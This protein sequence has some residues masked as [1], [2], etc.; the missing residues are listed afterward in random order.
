MSNLLKSQIYKIFF[1][2]QGPFTKYVSNQKCWQSL[3]KGGSGVKQML[4]IADKGG[5]GGA[6]PCGELRSWAALL[7]S[8]T[9]PLLFIQNWAHTKR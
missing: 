7:G 1:L 2:H 3:T 9:R 4:K 8:V 6:R 5:W